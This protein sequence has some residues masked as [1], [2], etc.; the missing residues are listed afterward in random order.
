MP[1]SRFTRG[2]RGWAALILLGTAASGWAQ[3]PGEP[4]QPVRSAILFIADGLRHDS[5][6]A[7]DA[8]TLLTVRRQGVEFANSHALFPTVTTPN[9]AAIATGHAPGDSGDFGNA[10][11][12]G[13]PAFEHGNFGRSAGSPVPFLENDLI[14]GDLD[15]HAGG[16]FLNES[17]LLALA[18]ARGF[19]TAA[20]G[21]LGPVGI[22][23]VSQLSPVNGSFSVPTTIILDDSTGSPRG[24]PLAP[25][26][27]SALSAAGLPLSPAARRRSAG[28]VDAQGGQEANTEQQRWF[29]DAAT[30][31]VLPA[32]VAAGKPF[33]LIF[34]SRDPDG[35]Q[36]NQGDSLN[37]LTP[38]INGPTSR[39]AVANADANLKQILDYV[40]GSPQLAAVTDLFVTSDHGFAT[41]SKHELDARGHFTHSYA[42]QLIYRRPDGSLDVRQ[43]S[44]PAGFLA[45]D[46]AHELG[47]PVF[48]PDIVQREDGSA[49]YRRVDPAL[50]ASRTSW[51]H[52][53]N[54]NALIGGT[55]A[56]LAQSDARIIVGANG[57]SDLIYIPD[58]DVARTRR[59]VEFLARQDYVGG[60]FVDSSFGAIPGAL[61]LS[62]VALEGSAQTP[63]P[64]IVVSFKSFLQ[65]PGN[66]LSAVQIADTPLQEGQGVHGSLARDNTFNSM[67]ALGPD[68]RRGFV[69]TL[70]VGNAD[71]APTL[72]RILGLELPARGALQGRVLTEALLG[73]GTSNAR[74]RRGTLVSSR[75][76]TGRVTR[77]EY[78]ELAGHRYLDRADFR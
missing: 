5:V 63:H 25:A 13:Y 50:P 45:I 60:I 72:A 3:S 8:P 71:I 23:D 68:F 40:R 46:L 11:Y 38:G 10:Q 77:L 51:Q 31:V 6:T 58:H 2:A 66:L 18:R 61:P 56:V 4:A 76:A 17:S 54:G 39:K 55:G 48:D 7:T 74:V 69:D 29:A 64:A 42:A 62:A 12:I 14:Q 15:E 65:Q 19:N 20:I 75:S 26:I 43:G 67:A 9:A 41:I 27:Q 59:V 73:A 30:R 52:P 57:G 36:H 28:D 21:K 24:V 53:V 34:W 37:A 70:P 44:L 47:E 78:Q 22:Q 35:T 49:H 16:N 1:L 33:V 32:F